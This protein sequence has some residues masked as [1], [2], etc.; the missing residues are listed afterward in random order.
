MGALGQ[1]QP[2]ELLLDM[3]LRH[4]ARDSVQAGMKQKVGGDGE[5]EVERGL[6]KDDT[7][8]RQRRHRVA[9][10][11]MAHHL[12]APG[13]SREQAGEQLE[14]RGLAGAIGTEQGNEFSGLGL[15]S[16]R[17]RWREPARSS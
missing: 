15:Q 6:L 16:S 2:R 1:S 4:G 13:I 11:V 14:Q 5:L 9:R 3:S 17:R 8:S 7:E 10:H 12:D